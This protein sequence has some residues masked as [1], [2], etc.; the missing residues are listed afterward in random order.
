MGYTHYWARPREIPAPLFDSIR[1]EFS[2][3]ILPLNDRGV[4]LAGWDGEAIPEITSEV[5]SFNGQIA[6]GHSENED[7]VIPYPAPDAH[8]IGASSTAIVGDYHGLGVL[9][10]HRCCGGKCCCET[11]R[12]E[13]IMIPDSGEEP[14]NNGLFIRGVKTAFRPYDIA[15]TAALIV[16]KRHLGDLFLVH[17]NGGE[18]QWSDAKRLCQDILGYGEWFG[19]VEEAA[20]EII[21]DSAGTPRVR[22]YL[23][24]MLIGS[25]TPV[26]L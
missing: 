3:L 17:T 18:S 25:A 26:V 8:G 24:R 12:L 21:H 6:C 11:F 4:P 5:I 20:E 2:R 15:V 9:L 22:H 10:K 14:D 23:S 16:A 1:D 19:I 13:R 7:I